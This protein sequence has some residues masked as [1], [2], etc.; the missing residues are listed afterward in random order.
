MAR[1]PK[2]DSPTV[3]PNALD[4]GYL[5]LFVGQAMN[6]ATQAALAQKG[7]ADVRSSH[8]YVI[9]HLVAGPRPIG[10]VAERL[11]VSQQAAS[12]SIAELEALGYVERLASPDDKRVTQ[13]ALTARGREVVAAGRK[14]RAALEKKLVAAHGEKALAAARATLAGVLA[15][16]GGAEAVRERR[17]RQPR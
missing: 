10:D 5:A 3:D 8:G 1:A 9:Q 7:H 17:V 2:T 12:K 14:A 6:T 15:T 11:G 4:L 16:L 13:A